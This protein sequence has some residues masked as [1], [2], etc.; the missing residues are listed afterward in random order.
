MSSS[1]GSAIRP[2]SPRRWTERELSIQQEYELLLQRRQQEQANRHAQLRHETM[3]RRARLERRHEQALR[4]EAAEAAEAEAAAQSEELARRERWRAQRET[5]RHKMQAKVRERK[6][7]RA[8]QIVLKL[9][10][11]VRHERTHQTAAV[12]VQCYARRWLAQLAARRA[13]SELIQRSMNAQQAAWMAK[14]GSMAVLTGANGHHYLA[15]DIIT[16]KPSSPS[17]DGDTVDHQRIIG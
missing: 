11:Q 17:G 1:V 14:L 4:V 13:R 12:R 3:I 9:Q 7:A 5:E 10:Q 6:M 15:G 8:Q 16:S 2:P